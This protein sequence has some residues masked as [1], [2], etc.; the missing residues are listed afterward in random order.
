MTHW[1][2]SQPLYLAAQAG[3]AY[4]F[5]GGTRWL[6]YR[7]VPFVVLSLF[8]SFW[9][10][11]WTLGA[12]IN[13]KF[14]ML[15]Q[16]LAV[17]LLMLAVGESY[18]VV[19]LPP[20]T[21]SHGTRTGL[22]FTLAVLLLAYGIARGNPVVQA[23]NDL[24]VYI[25]F[26]CFLILGRYD[27]TWEA[28][29]KPLIVLFY[30]CLGLVILGLGMPQFKL[31]Y[32]GEEAASILQAQGERASAGSLALFGSMT[33][34]S[35]PLLF[36]LAYQKE[37]SDVWKILGLLTIVGYVI[38]A[39]ILEF[40]S[41]FAV[42][43]AYALVAMVVMPML[44]RKLKVG[45]GVL[46]LVMGGL[47]LAVLSVTANY[48]HLMERYSER[49]PYEGR[50]MEGTAMLE[51]LSGVQMLIG[52]GFGGAYR[53]AEGWDPGKT[54]EAGDYVSRTLHAGILMP[55]LKGG[56]ILW[57]L[58]LS[59]L[60]PMFMR[61]PPGWYHSRYNAAAMTVMLV[62]SAYVTI[63]PAPTMESFMFI[64]VSGLSLARAAAPGVAEDRVYYV[65]AA[66]VPQRPYG[67]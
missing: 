54:W 33:L 14:L 5:A 25:T 67:L 24:W 10:M 41:R 40:R 61:K 63:V 21:T 59:F 56:A 27:E 30:V 17:G 31:A 45:T 62:Y 8:S 37:R 13:P 20:Q 4:D 38:V 47:A 43:G 49:Q 60:V 46:V 11:W 58:C 15:P 26:C 32:G 35:W 23:F 2:E 7:L 44:Q 12:T 6:R 18:R 53:A 57:L 3:E 22:L 16:Y 52:K 29:E 34:E 65:S 66:N 28:L 36:A 51:D 9:T 50:L 19:R 39:V 42:A 64:I 55:I 1:T 48:A